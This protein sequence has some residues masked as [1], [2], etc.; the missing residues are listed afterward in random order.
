[1]SKPL[2]AA[3]ETTTGPSLYGIPVGVPEELSLPT[4]YRVN[5]EIVAHVKSKKNGPRSRGFHPSELYGLCPVKYYL[6]DQALDGFASPD[7]AVIRDSMKVVRSVLDTEHDGVRPGRAPMHLVA[8]FHG[9]DAIHEWQQYHYGERGYLWGRWKCPHCSS[10]AT[11]FM[12]RMVVQNIHGHDQMVGAYCQSCKGGNYLS[13]YRQIKWL[14]IEPWLGLKEWEIDGHCDGIFLKP[15]KGRLLPFIF[16]IKSINENGYMGRYGDPLPRVEHVAQASQYV[17]AARQTFPWLR[18]LRHVYFCYV[19]KNAQRDTKEFAIAADMQVV[20]RMT[21]NMRIVLDA[22]RAGA[23]PTVRHSNCTGI[24]SK[25]ARDCPLV[26]RCYGRKPPANLFD[27]AF[28]WEDP[29]L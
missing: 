15:Y 16:E 4:T 6:Y 14:Y 27:P 17:W 26:E 1:M 3:A 10:I 25:T 8:D 2:P 9:G 13:R 21:N 23:P 24:E 11:G 12:P 19:N 18:D 22:K 29:P 28:T 20:E 5:K 7:P